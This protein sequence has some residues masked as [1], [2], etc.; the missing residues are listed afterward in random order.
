M[1][2]PGTRIVH[3]TSVHSARDTRI[4]RECATLARAGFDVSLVARHECDEVI[5]G[6]R[7]H[8]IAKSH[9]RIDRMTRT[10]RHVFERAL[11]LDAR[12]YHV[13][14]PELLPIALLLRLRGR[15]VI[16]DAHE[17][18]PRQLL[19]KTYLPALWRPA[20]ARICEVT[21]HAIVRRLSAVVC[22]WPNIAETFD[23]HRKVLVQNFPY[24]G[25]YASVDAAPLGARP[26][27]VVYCGGL[28]I[29]RGLREMLRAIALVQVPGAKLILAGSFFDAESERVF[30]QEADP[31]RV[32]LIEWCSRERVRALL[33]QA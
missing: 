26:R 3:L 8:G 25:E 14:D 10:T 31:A 6:V 19:G 9:G 15:D 12:F 27:N 30:A 24:P 2:E 11:E 21:M 20:L 4:M 13:H 17:D 23:H 33:A 28:S 5:D 1:T 16:Y 29:S 22:A 18:F 32:E 7:V